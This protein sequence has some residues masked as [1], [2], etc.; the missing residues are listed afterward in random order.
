MQ[1]K[2]NVMVTTPQGQNVGRIDRVVLEPRTREITHI[3][4][5]KGALFTEDKL[6]PVGLV[7][8]ANENEIV[9]RDDAGDLHALSNFEETHY[10][11]TD[12]SY[13]D[14]G[15]A[16]LTPDYA[17][18]L[19]HYPPVEGGRIGYL[20]DMPRQTRVA[21]ADQNIPAGTVALKEGAKVISLEGRHMGNIE[22][23]LT[24]PHGEHVTHFVIS[25][26]LLLKERK[27]VPLR[28]VNSIGEEAVHLLVEANQLQ[29]LN[30]YLG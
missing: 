5:R 24:G 21:D 11:A 6:V 29:G 25:K 15:A 7:A 16:P 28:W 10:V 3:V 1:Y 23:M 30:E 14:P 12:G 4:V 17:P 13:L 19:Y 9:L 20:P 8:A 18:S 2:Q 22:R 27:L 26:G